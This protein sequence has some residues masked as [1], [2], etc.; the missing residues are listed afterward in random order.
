[1]HLDDAFSSPGRQSVVADQLAGGV[2]GLACVDVLSTAGRVAC[3]D[4]DGRELLRE[5]QGDVV[6]DRRSVD[7]LPVGRDV[8]DQA[9]GAVVRAVGG[10][11]GHGVEE[12]RSQVVVLHGH[13]EHVGTRLNARNVLRG[14]NAR[15]AAAAVAGDN[16]ELEGIS[17]EGEAEPVEVELLARDADVAEAIVRQHALTVDDPCEGKVGC[18]RRL[19]G[20][21]GRGRRGRR[22]LGGCRRWRGGTRC[23]CCRGWCRR[24]GRGGL[25]TVEDDS[26][27]DESHDDQSDD[28]RD[29]VARRVVVVHPVS[30][31]SHSDL[32]PENIPEWDFQTG[33]RA[34]MDVGSDDE[35][36]TCMSIKDRK[37][38]K[39]WYELQ[40]NNC[41][42]AKFF[43]GFVTKAPKWYIFFIL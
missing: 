38:K 10:E 42:I 37:L 39:L 14:A 32:L 16:D 4:D 3:V 23:R 26:A 36:G 19:F 15:N 35:S 29:P 7:D 22:R 11:L 28:Q 2:G 12:C 31:D 43:D 6:E 9:P 33:G 20:R 17:Q 24:L 27:S 18:R 34:V 41:S 21:R 5:D 25:V 30:S 8:A 40:E 1:M 13:A